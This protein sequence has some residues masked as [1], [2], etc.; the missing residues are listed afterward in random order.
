MEETTAIILAGGLGTRLRTV[1][2]D[3][4][5]VLAPVAG[6]PFVTYLLDQ[7]RDAGISDIVLSTGYLAEQF[8]TIIG[9]CY[10]DQ[11]IRYCHEESPLGTGGAVKLAGR[12]V[13]RDCVLVMN[14]DSYT[15]VDLA[16]LV[17]GHQQQGQDASLLLVSVD[18]AS[19]YG[20]VKV[21][22]DG[23]VVEFLEKQTITGGG[24]INSGIYVLGKYLLEEI[25]DGKCSLETDVLPNWLRRWQVRAYITQN[26]FID[27][28]IPKAYERSHR[29]M[30]RLQHV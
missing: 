11:A 22:V 29:F 24:L 30:R 18:D 14:G 13:Q 23:R 16:D 25:P 5:K 15:D 20:T 21:G 8:E 6:R 3:R 19:R 9:Q 28:G 1:V 7:L 12:M 4:P 10:G 17:G 27:I 2:S 26:P